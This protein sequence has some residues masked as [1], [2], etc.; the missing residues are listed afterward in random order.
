M[1]EASSPLATASGAPTVREVDERTVED[2]VLHLIVMG[3]NMFSMH[4]LPESGAVT[5][6]RDDDDDVRIDEPN[7]SRHHARLHVGAVLEIEDLGSKN[8]TRL[9][10]NLL[11]AGQRAPVLPGEAISIGCATLMIQRRRPTVRMRRLPTHAYFEGRLEEE[12]DNASSSGRV[13]A[14][15]RL[16][17]APGTSAE[18]VGE[19]VAPHVR[20]GD[21]MAAYG[22]DEYE[23]ILFEHDAKR[24]ADFAARVLALLGGRNVAA[25]TGVAFFPADARSADGLIARACERVQGRNVSATPSSDD[26]RCGPEMRRVHLLAK[27]AA[28]S[29]INVLI[30]GE[31]GVG[32]EV[33]AEII[34]GLSPRAGK[35]FVRINCATLTPTLFEAELFGHERAAFTD[36]REAKPGLLETAE[37]GTV[38]LDEIGELPLPLQAKLL[39][40]IE[41]HEVMRVGAV[42]PRT[43]DVRFL[44]ATNRVLED[45]VARGA[46]RQDLYYRLNGISLLIPPLRARVD[47]IEPL[48]TSFVENAARLGERSAPKIAPAAM[49]LLL[50]YAWPGNI[51]ELRNTMERA[52]LLSSGDAI[53]PEDLPLEK[54]RGTPVSMERVPEAAPR[55]A[56]SYAV[57][58]LD[59]E[60]RLD[61]ERIVESLSLCS[62]NQTRAAKLLG[63]SRRT[64]CARLKA[65]GIPRP[66]VTGNS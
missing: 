38:L 33:L 3:A 19:I 54:L 34:H 26:V 57:A 23:M 13:F 30:V 46:F 55:A 51:R 56:Q 29:N 36:A 66:R 2:G 52:L 7:A 27:R 25:R 43:V 65:Y 28:V 10:G 61:Y 39:R 35:P 37:G 45:E 14:V 62:G 48:A 6:G 32:K 20:P 59:E 31:T 47:E 11:T 44:A 24:V 41:T 16:H 4:P 8:G 1:A 9:R 60:S 50:S 58:G 63:M 53:T 18:A 12:C 5:I 42:K 49:K 40:A 21:V 17:V 64:F 15:L 22:P